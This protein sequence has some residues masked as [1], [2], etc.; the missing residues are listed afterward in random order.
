VY[1][2]AL[3]DLR[4]QGGAGYRLR[5]TDDARALEVA[6]AQ[7][8]IEHAHPGDH[9]LVLDARE[10][11]VGELSLALGQAGIGILALTPELATLEDLFFRLTEGPG[12]VNGA[13]SSVEAQPA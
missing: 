11:D 7:A 1:E 9:G 8:G 2:G 6:R 4:R 12:A 13:S 3:S 10:R 5:T